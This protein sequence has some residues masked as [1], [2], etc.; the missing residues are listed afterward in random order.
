VVVSTGALVH[1]DDEELAAGLAHERGHI[2][3][4][5]RWV[6]LAAEIARAVARP[7]PGTRHAMA[8]LAFHIER[9]ADRW[10]LRRMHDPLALASAICKAATLPTTGSALANIAQHG[11]ADRLGELTEGSPKSRSC[12]VLRGL[13][14]LLVMATA[15]MAVVVPVAA[16]QGFSLERRS[17]P[18]HC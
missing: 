12:A 9:D 10:A 1:L 11:V 3:R 13:A 2:Q 18:S 5:H 8:E 6:L 16:A 4:R 7:L 15:A 14:I 17:Q